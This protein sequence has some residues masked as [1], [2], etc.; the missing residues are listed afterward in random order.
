MKRQNRTISRIRE[1]AD[2]LYFERGAFSAECF[3]DACIKAKY[4]DAPPIHRAGYWLRAAGYEGDK[5]RITIYA[6]K[7]A[8]HEAK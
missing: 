7:G 1:I 5:S 8:L 2:G 4:R 3:V 6:P